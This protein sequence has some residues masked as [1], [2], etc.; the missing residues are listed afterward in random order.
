MLDDHAYCPHCRQLLRKDA[1][2]PFPQRPVRC[3]GCRLLVGPGRSRRA[4]GG[5]RQP[6]A[7]QASPVAADPV[8]DVLTDLRPAPPVVG[9]E[10]GALPPHQL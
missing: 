4:D 3:S 5:P 7:A 6:Q 1:P 9:L 10:H 8:L 2:H